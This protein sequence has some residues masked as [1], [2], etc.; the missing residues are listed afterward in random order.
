MSFSAAFSF[1]SR[2]CRLSVKLVISRVNFFLR[3]SPSSTR[4][5]ASFS[6]FFFQSAFS[7]CHLLIEPSRLI[8]TCLSSSISTIRVLM[9]LSRAVILVSAALRLKIDRFGKSKLLRIALQSDCFFM[10]MIARLK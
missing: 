5:R 10:I 9:F 7:A 1:C 8:L 2:L 6:Y 3:A 4:R